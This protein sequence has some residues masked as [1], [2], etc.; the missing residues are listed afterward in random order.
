MRLGGLDIRTT[1]NIG[2]KNIPYPTNIVNAK[3][4]MFVAQYRKNG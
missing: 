2:S 4:L 3:V 1:L